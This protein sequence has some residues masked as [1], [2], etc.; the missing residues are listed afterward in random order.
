[1]FARNNRCLSSIY[2]FSIFFLKLKLSNYHGSWDSARGR[3][4]GGAALLIIFITQPY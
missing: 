3:R 4:M 2:I 1:M